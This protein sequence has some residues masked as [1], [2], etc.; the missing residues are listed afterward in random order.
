MTQQFE[1]ILNEV[2]ADFDLRLV[3]PHI[4]LCR[5]KHETRINFPIACNALGRYPLEYLT[6]LK[7]TIPE[8]IGVEP[9][10]GLFAITCSTLSLINEPYYRIGNALGR[11]I[12]KLDSGTARTEVSTARHVIHEG[13]TLALYLSGEFYN[14]LII[15]PQVMSHARRRGYRAQLQA[16]KTYLE[17]EEVIK[18]DPEWVFFSLPESEVVAQ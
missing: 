2:S 13:L 15:Q 18:S 12:S 8:Q 10:K 5:F 7:F 3:D 6:G 16:W 17:Q 11:L 9:L 4:E 1:A 14:H